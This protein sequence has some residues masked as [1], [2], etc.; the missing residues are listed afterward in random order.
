MRQWKRRSWQRNALPLARTRTNG[1]NTWPRGIM[2]NAAK[3]NDTVHNARVN[4]ATPADQHSKHTKN[5][6]SVVSEIALNCNCV[7]LISSNINLNNFG[8][9]WNPKIQTYP[10]SNYILLRNTI[11]H[12][13]MTQ[14]YP[15]NSSL[16]LPHKLPSISP[17]QSSRIRSRMH[18]KQIKAQAWATCHYSY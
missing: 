16:P 8:K 10:H 7:S 17:Q 6:R 15:R 14:A 3:R 5:T 2:R 9:C 18:S 12:Y 1:R 4:T 11:E 13:S